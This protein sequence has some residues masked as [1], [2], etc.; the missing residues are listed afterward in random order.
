MKKYIGVVVFMTGLI[1]LG[2]ELSAARLM[3]PYFGTS[4]PVWSA[5]IGLI[6]LALSLGYW[7]GGRWADRSPTPPTLFK[8]LGISGI[9][10]SLTP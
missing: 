9:L 7:L 2:A 10:L 6:L 8:I 5:L 3:A 1:I 4:M